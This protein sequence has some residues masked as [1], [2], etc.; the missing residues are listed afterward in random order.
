M[1]SFETLYR[2][3]SRCW[4]SAEDIYL[5]FMFDMIGERISFESIERL[6]LERALQEMSLKK[7]LKNKYFDFCTK[8]K[9]FKFL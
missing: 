7:L 4:S 1:K 6:E 2:K 5:V 9:Q 8:N 3:A